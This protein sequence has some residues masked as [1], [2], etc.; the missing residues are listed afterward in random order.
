MTIGNELWRTEAGRHDFENDGDLSVQSNT[1]EPPHGGTIFRFFEIGPEFATQSLT[2]VEKHSH[3]AEWFAGMG[4]GAHL[5]V[6]TRR[7]PAMHRSRTTDYIVLLS[8]EITL[9]LD[10]DEVDLKPFDTVIQRGTNHACCNRGIVP[11]LLMAVLVDGGEDP[12]IQPVTICT[13]DALEHHSEWALSLKC[14]Q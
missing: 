10:E 9:L 12:M 7:P 13:R 11:V 8:G 5:R 2:Q 1:L 4:G 3:A 6:D 14:S